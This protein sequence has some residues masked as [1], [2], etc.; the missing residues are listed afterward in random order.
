MLLLLPL[1]LPGQTAQLS[2]VVK[3]P[4]GGVIVTAKITLTNQGTEV[5]RG[6]STNGDGVY[7]IPFL[8]PGMYRALIEATGFQAESRS[9]VRLEVGQQA[10]WDVTL[11]VGKTEQSLTVTA[12]PTSLNTTDGSVSTIVD[13]NF[14]ENLP[15][16]GRGFNSLL[17]LTP[18]VATAKTSYSA[19]GQFNVNGQ[20]SSSNYFSVDGVS[21]NTGTTAGAGLNQTGAGTLPATS[22]LGGMNALVSV[23][24]L[25][26]F[27]VMTSTFAPE[28]GRTP[29]AQISIATRSGT[30]QF[31]GDVFDY[32]RNDKMDANNWFA[33]QTRLRRPALRQNDFGGVVGGPLVRARTFFFFSYEGLRLRQPQTAVNYGVPSLAARQA[34]PS[35]LQPFLNAFPLPTGADLP[36]GFAVD[37]AT[38]SNPGSFDSTALRVD[39]SLGRTILFGRYAYSPSS[40][41]TRGGSYPLSSP[42]SLTL[43]NWS[44]TA[45]ATST[46]SAT[47]TNEA[48][49]NWTSTHA[50]GGNI[51]DSFGG[52]QPIS[53]AML[54]PSSA[55]ADNSKISVNF[56]A[57]GA[58]LAE[59]P[60]AANTQRQANL[61][62]NISVAKANHVF[63]VGL[64]VR[65]LRPV[66]GQPPFN[67]LATFSSVGDPSKA[68]GQQTPGTFLSGI[69]SSGSVSTRPLRT[70]MQY[71]NFSS[72]A[73]DT[74]RLS[75]RL[76]TTFG[77]RWDVAPPP[78]GPN[79]P[80]FAL[81]S[82]PSPGAIAFASSGTA[83]W[84]T[85]YK[86]IAPRLGIAYRIR[87]LPDFALVLRAG[88][89]TFYDLTGGYVGTQPAL[90]PNVS[91][92]N[93]VSTPFP[94]SSIVAAPPALPGS[95][96]YSNAVGVDPAL[97][98]ARVYQWNMAL[99]QQVGRYGTVSA[100]YVGALGRDLARATTLFNPNPTFASLILE[101]SNSTS[102]FHSLQ[103]QFRGH[104]GPR[105]QALTSYSWSHSIDTASSDIASG[106][107]PISQIG[108]NSDRGP[109]DFDVR[110]SF[111]TALIVSSSQFQG[112]WW[113]GLLRDWSTDAIFQARSAFPFD[114]TVIRDLGYGSY[115]FR[116]DIVPG[117]PEY[118]SDPNAGGGRRLDNSQPQG[119]SNEVGAFLIPATLRQGDLSRN[120]T[121]GFGMYQVDVDLRR[122]FSLTERLKLQV[123]VEFFNI[124][125]HPDFADPYGIIGV[126]SPTG[127]LTIQS[128]FGR[129]QGMLG[130]QLGAGGLNGGLSP[131]Y[132]IGGPRSTQLSMKVIF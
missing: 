51:L 47:I 45:G 52:A 9:D 55:L 19:Q 67:E 125:N 6:A 61:L 53:P 48:R 43:G 123:K 16:N 4:S 106:A 8:Q 3:D 10:R 96:P 20:R 49:G 39:H 120:A 26:E 72:F 76:T 90:A 86:N 107:P 59:G 113:S 22:I 80:L 131:L 12:G 38:Y 34:A 28:Y 122:T 15:L 75:S 35:A 31:H 97:K 27:R 25:L 100:V 2:G 60:N 83:L 65:V 128:P 42:T 56:S 1:R 82:I 101:Q 118:V 23:D 58:L 81:S 84:A 105:V 115:L 102:D 11:S 44:I 69:A 93:F 30:N 74:W 29:G 63:K 88:A 57:A 108:P 77:V 119:A 129:S 121:R 50:T 87:D 109:S 111:S 79:R 85:D 24:A 95:P 116:P 66:V 78:T 62:D 130:G 5:S 117:Q 64:D 36:N 103:I 46:L 32:F 33:N 89:G 99:E 114:V 54:F 18:G 21:A 73:Q 110:H 68:S 98:T 41:T 126:L 13:R 37:N 104:L 7:L 71:L 70:G 40:L 127:V 132:Q 112:A 17:E 91:T 14:V 94:Y 124:L 92:R